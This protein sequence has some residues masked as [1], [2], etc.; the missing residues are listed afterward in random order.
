MA[1]AESSRAIENQVEEQIP[2]EATLF[3]AAGRF[4]FAEPGEGEEG[5]PVRL[6]A[7]DAQPIQ[8]W[9]WGK[10]AHDM[11]GVIH[12]DR[13]AIDWCHDPDAMLGFVDQV[14][15]DSGKG[16][17]LA[18][19]L[20]TDLDEKAQEIHRKAAA[21]VPYESSIDWRGP[22]VIEFVDA[23]QSSEVNGYEFEGPG[24]IVRKWHLR[25][26]AICPHGVDLNTTTE[27]SE[28][29]HA[30]GITL[31]SHT[32]EVI[33][34]KTVKGKK[35]DQASQ[36]ADVQQAQDTA[37]QDQANEPNEPAEPTK[38]DAA[39][40]TAEK[41]DR[42]SQDS[43]SEPASGDQQQSDA[44]APGQKYMDAFGEDLG[45]KYFARG[46]SFEAATVEHGR[47][48]AQENATLRDENTQLKD[49]IAALRGELGSDDP[50]SFTPEG[51]QADT[52]ADDNAGDVN[53]QRFKRG[54]KLPVADRN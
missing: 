22:A 12:R 41:V 39:A 17:D 30:V 44:P 40:G 54:I 15:A 9:Y 35:T 4:Q 32:G 33:M 8:H 19:R 10:I 50:A 45:S 51:T 29:G 6:H 28:A 34:P 25:G 38:Q 31:F 2:R 18:G 3:D 43:A 7:R 20:L 24:Y 13:L 49:Q 5:V 23:G 11:S 47:H 1:T 46:L 37:Q 52:Q 36:P 16:L 27:F 48:L 42:A 14:S 21:G 53:L 26:V